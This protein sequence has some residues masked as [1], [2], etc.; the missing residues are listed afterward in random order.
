MG[1]FNSLG[2][3]FKTARKF[4]QTFARACLLVCLLN[5]LKENLLRARGSDRIIA[6]EENCPLG[7]GLGLGWRLS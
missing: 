1:S 5:I 4:C 3:I 2:L 6:P 7:L